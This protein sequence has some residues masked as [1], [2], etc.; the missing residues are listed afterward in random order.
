MRKL[1]ALASCALTLALSPSGVAP[2]RLTLHEGT[3]IAAALSADGRTIA[4][5]LLGAIWT[6]PAAGGTARRITDELMDARQ[7]A[8]ASD[9]SRIA[10]QAYRTS[11][12]NI[13]SVNADGSALKQLTWGPFDDREPHWSPDRTRIAFSSD[14]SGNYDIWVMTL[15]SGDLRQVTKNPAN[16]F[17][18]AW[19]PDGREIA[20]VSDREGGRGVYAVSVSVA[21]AGATAERLVRAH[22][23][24]LAG[25]AWSPD[26][27]TVAFNTI[28]GAKSSLIVGA[29]DIAGADEDVFPFRSQWVSPTE[30]LYTA[31]GKIKR[32][33]ASGGAATTIEFSA[34]VSFERPAFTPK[35]RDFAKAGPQPVRGLMHP[36]ISPDGKQVAFSALGDL[37]VMPVGGAPRRITNDPFI[38]TG[39][40]WSPDG[41]WLAYSSDRA[42]SMD[43]WLRDVAT[44]VERRVTSSGAAT[45]A[46]WSPEGNRIAM[47]R[48]G[49]EIQ[50]VDVS[51]FIGVDVPRD[52]TPPAPTATFRGG[53]DPGGPSWSSDGRYLVT[54]AL[55]PNSTR[56]REG[57]NEVLRLPVAGGA[58]KWIDPLPQKSIGMREDYGPVWSPDGTQMVAIVDG[59]LA[60]FPV[61]REGEALG[62]VRMLSTEL[63]NSP[64]WAGD[65]R[66]VLYQ[67][68]DRF[69]LVDVVDGS[70]REIDPKLTWT[71]KSPSAVTRVVHAGR[72]WDGTSNAVRENVDIVVEGNRIKSVEPHRAALHTGTTVDASGQTVIPGLIDIHSHMTKAFGESLGRIWLSWGITT[73]RNP[74][75]NPFEAV[76]DKEAV[77]SG[78]RIGPRTFSTGDPIDGTRIYYPGGTT[79]DG[80]AELTLQ[81]ARAERLGYDL[82]KT[83]VRLPDLLQ[84]RVVE[85]AHKHGMPVTSHELYPAV[86]YGADGVEHI[87]GTSRRGYS[88]KQSQLMRTYGD[89][90]EL[91]A[92]SGMTITP[93]VGIQGGFQLQTI[94]DSSWLADPRMALYPPA[95]VDGA[96][97]MAKVPHGQADLDQR[98][99]LVVPIEKTVARIVHAGGRVTAGTDSPIS[100]YGLAL[101]MEIE[102]YVSGGLTP[103]EALKTATSVNAAAL[104]MGADLGAIAPGRFADLVMLDGNPLVNIRDLRKVKQVMKDGELYGLDALLRRPAAS[105]GRR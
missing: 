70:V 8:W 64:T 42:G 88:P 39:A 12:W 48:N 23:G 75:A 24:A 81:L 63:A 54:A 65:S 74:A 78:R 52:T 97:A 58:E 82:M 37:W 6:M 47:L 103:V 61:S 32:R 43:I 36:A 73:V 99:A 83:Y 68:D 34:D 16:D 1:L 85:E 19:S 91:L 86:A 77:E 104:G 69:K 51:R 5:D 98:A 33:P 3:N 67:A 25:P 102:Q 71:V 89:V 41:R 49:S 72:L 50:I 56:F 4:F 100:P 38:E 93:T 92:A 9:G 31:D 66:H 20:F 55:H 11:T 22:A 28:V 7:P 26:G 90:I 27:R 62:P 13:W 87:R 14:R 21:D 105:G 94:R 80:G 45:N 10:F 53:Y 2:V 30:L 18:P 60:A 101:L 76:E 15:A 44:G 57:S 59:R 95:V 29:T 35:H 84:R 96:R 17:A 46:A 40:A 79:I